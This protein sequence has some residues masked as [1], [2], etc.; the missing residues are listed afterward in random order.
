MSKLD[1]KDGPLTP[2]NTA[3]LMASGI[4]QRKAVNL[5]MLREGPGGKAK[6]K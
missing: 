2:A 1:I 4:P 6:G 5:A 3:Q